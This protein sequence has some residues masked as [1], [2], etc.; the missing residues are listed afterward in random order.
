MMIFLLSGSHA[1]VCS[2]CTY[3]AGDLDLGDVHILRFFV[4]TITELYPVH[5]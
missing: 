4:I 1:E 3:K 5:V 2:V